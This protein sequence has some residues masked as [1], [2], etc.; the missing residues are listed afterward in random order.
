MIRCKMLLEN[1]L[2]NKFCGTKAVFS[3]AFAGNGFE[4]AGQD[5]SALFHVNNPEVLEKLVPGKQYYFDITP[6]D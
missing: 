3:C 2:T 6:V 1:V 5:G 4:M